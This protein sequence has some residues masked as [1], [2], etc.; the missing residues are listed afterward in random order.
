MER[1]TIIAGSGGQGVLFLG[2]LIAYSA[3]WDRKEVTWFPSYGAEIRGGTATCTVIVSN[4]MIGSPVVRNTDF[5]IVMNEASLEK[6]QGRLVSGG[7][8]IYDSSLIK[9]YKP[10]P[11]IISSPVPASEIAAAAKYKNLANMVLI[12]A[13]SAISGLI[14][15]DAIN[16]ALADVTPA[17]RKNL[18][19][20]NKEI[21]MKGCLFAK[22]SKSSD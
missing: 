2:K 18:L 13:F 4:D 3:L 7:T 17:R 9:S 12:G 8:I 21:I 6:Y 11:D 10:R 15:M 5:L 16:D 1:R 20:I 22:D 19:P 14:S